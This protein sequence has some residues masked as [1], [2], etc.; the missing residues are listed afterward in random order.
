MGAERA[1]GDEECREEGKWQVTGGPA[2]L[3]SILPPAS[4][5]VAAIAVRL[6]HDALLEVEFDFS[7]CLAF[8]AKGR[9][10]KK[11]EI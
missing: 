2:G 10:E 4:L 3:P 1:L 6:V 5:R 9:R 8:A 7:H 11:T